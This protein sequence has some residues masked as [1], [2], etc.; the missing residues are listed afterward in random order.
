[1]STRTVSAVIAVGLL[2]APLAALEPAGPGVVFET[3]I[4][5]LRRN[6]TQAASASVEGK[7]IKVDVPGEGGQPSNAMIFRGDR[8]E[9]VAIDHGRRTYMVID[10]AT[11]KE[12]A[13]QVGTAMS[14]MQQMLQNLPPEQRA[15]MEQA[16]RG[17][18]MGGAMGPPPP[19]AELRKTNERAEH[20]G[21]DTVKYEVLRGERKVREMWVTDWSNLPASG[22]VRGAFESMGTFAKEVFSALS[23]IAGQLN[24]DVY[25]QMQQADGYP[26]LVTEFD[27]SGQPTTETRLVSASERVIDPATFEP[28]TD[29]RRETM[30][31]M[32]G[33]R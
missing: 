32:R 11:I 26:V 28:P 5:D 7:L 4:K 13:A 30:G 2:A 15:A 29:Y 33:R 21:Y 3:E 25:E 24:L 12:L 6:T 10:Q 14:Q 27:E 19:P 8:Q 17:R 31:G 20:A 22:E 9:L 1:M 16:M 23:Q 18:G